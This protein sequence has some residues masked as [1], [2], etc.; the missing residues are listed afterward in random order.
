MAYPLALTCF[1]W[2]RPTYCLPDPCFRPRRHRRQG[3]KNPVFAR[4]THREAWSRLI[5]NAWQGFG[6]IAFYGAVT[7]ALLTGL[8]PFAILQILQVLQLFWGICAGSSRA[9]Y[10][11]SR[12]IHIQG[13]VTPIVIA[14]RL[15]QIWE[16]FKNKS[17][18][19]LSFITWFL[20]FG[21]SVARIFTTIQEVD[22]P[23]GTITLVT[24]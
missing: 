13:C 9:P 8:V 11:E 24:S 3:I 17:T 10:T 20:N 19:Q 14:S 18:G 21:G 7:Y 4:L 22:D 5:I 16:S 6:G 15:P 23:L 2:P 1:L 12:V